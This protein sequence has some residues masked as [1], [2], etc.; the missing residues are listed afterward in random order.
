VS[1][2]TPPDADHELKAR[3]SAAGCTN[4]LVIADFYKKRFYKKRSS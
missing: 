4:L 3:L 1:A 2:C